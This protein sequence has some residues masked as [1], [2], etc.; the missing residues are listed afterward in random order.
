MVT[1]AKRALILLALLIGVLPLPAVALA[2]GPPDPLIGQ[3]FPIA[4]VPVNDEENVA[5]AHDPGR[6]RFLVVYENDSAL[7]AICMN[8][9]GV[10][11][12]SFVVPAT[13][14]S[15]PDVVYNGWLDEYLIVWDQELEVWGARVGGICW[16]GPGGIGSAFLILWPAFNGMLVNPAVAHNSHANHRDY[17]VVAETGM[18]DAVRDSWGIIARR[19]YSASAGLGAA[20]VVTRTVGGPWNLEPDVAYN[21]D[22]NEYLVVYTHDPSFGV[23]LQATDVYGRR[24]ASGGGLL[25]EH[26]IDDDAYG[27]TGPAVA[28]YRLNP[29]AP[30]LVV[31]SDFSSGTANG[32]IWGRMIAGD[33][34]P[35]FGY[36]P[37]AVDSTQDTKDPAVASSEALG[38]YTV[39]W[40][41]WEADYN[42]RARRVMGDGTMQDSFTVSL[43]DW[44]VLVGDNESAPAVAGGSPMA[45]A[46]WQQIEFLGD[47]DVYGRFIGY[48]PYVPL[49]LRN[50]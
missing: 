26:A 25:A 35:L 24:V 30:Y 28:A 16:P 15:N 20:Y 34:I 3:P 22:R 29:S 10:T 14:G 47:W 41:K 50:A 40:A 1:K 11:V 32:S 44:F 17:L 31:Y 36:I 48:R 38:G 9:H 46:A 37:I 4:A 33:G 27:Q 18:T 45:L 2:A 19:V 43:P 23:D 12:T 7:N 5:V 21:L 13:D 8:A 39:A 49:V 42:V 6:N